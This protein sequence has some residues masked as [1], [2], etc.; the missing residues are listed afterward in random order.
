M[1]LLK[2]DNDQL[3]RAEMAFLYQKGKDE[4]IKF[5]ETFRSVPSLLARAYWRN[6]LPSELV[7]K[8]PELAHSN[9]FEWVCGIIPLLIQTTE[10]DPFLSRF[11]EVCLEQHHKGRSTAHD[12]LD[13]WEEHQ[14]E[15]MVI[16]PSDQDAV[17]VMTIHKAKGLESP[18]VILPWADFDLKPRKDS[19]FWTSQLSDQYG[20]YQLL[21]LSF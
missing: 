21:P 7:D 15:Q 11:L 10:A 5:N 13:W 18:I 2:D 6:F 12:F 19:L 8:W 4:S 9:I 3:A 1:Y 14:E 16:F 20:K 17:R